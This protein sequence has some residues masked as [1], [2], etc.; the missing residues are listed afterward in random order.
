M[1]TL[2]PPAS[3]PWRWFP[4]LILAVLALGAGWIWLARVPT[5]TNLAPARPLPLAGRPAPDFTL[6]QPGGG[7]LS[8]SDLRGQAV[9]LNFWATWCGPCE[10]EMPELQQAAQKYGNS[11]L[12]VLGVNQ[13]EPE[14][15]VTDYL[16]RLGISFP[17]VLDKAVQVS[18]LYRVNSLPTTFFIDR[19][20][21]LRD[22]VIGQMNT[23][24]LQQHLRSIYP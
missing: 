14:D 6:S 16:E 11:G 9:V 1:T 21:I 7:E 15:I 10:A 20:G 5:P 23:A 19:D 24:V 3:R 8:L 13:A 18:E 4:L 12:V 2:S 22:E 17:I